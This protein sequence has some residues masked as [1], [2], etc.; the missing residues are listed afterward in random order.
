LKGERAD[1]QENQAVHQEG[2]GFP[3]VDDWAVSV[4]RDR[5]HDFAAWRQEAKLC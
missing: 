1:D 4:V 2:D 5:A 3:E